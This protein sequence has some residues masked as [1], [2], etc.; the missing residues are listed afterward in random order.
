MKIMLHYTWHD[1][2]SA[3]DRMMN[4]RKATKEEEARP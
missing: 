1:Q 3:H 4:W 2:R